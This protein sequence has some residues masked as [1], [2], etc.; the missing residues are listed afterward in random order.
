[1]TKEQ[2]RKNFKSLIRENNKYLI[3]E[4]EKL[5][6]SGELGYKKETDFALAKV[7]M[8]ALVGTLKDQWR[9]LTKE[10]EEEGKRLSYL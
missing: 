2:F 7:A 6:K 5:L 9:P 3:K 8:W 10:L 1:M 4:M